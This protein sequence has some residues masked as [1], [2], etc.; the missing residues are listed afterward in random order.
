M[1]DVNVRDSVGR[2]IAVNPLASP[3]ELPCGLRLRNRL[4]KAAMSDALGDG[5]CR[6]TDDQIDLCRRW[7]QG[8]VGRAD[9]RMDAGLRSDMTR[10][11]D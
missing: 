8:E 3:L 1:A 7:A 10:T 6:P 5:A 9:R 2:D 4:A 11:M